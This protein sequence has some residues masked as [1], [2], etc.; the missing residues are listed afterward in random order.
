M[1]KLYFVTRGYPTKDNSSFAFIQ[2]L[3]H[4]IADEGIECVV[5]APQPLLK[6]NRLR[7]YKWYD[8]TPK[9]NVITIIQPRYIPFGSLKFAGVK[10]TALSRERAL[11]R[12]MN[13]LPD[14]PDAVYAHFWDCALMACCYT[15][16]MNVPLI[17]V[18]GESAIKLEHYFSNR[19]I[20]KRKMLIDGTICVST[21]NYN[22]SV[23]LGLIDKTERVLI[24]PNAIDTS[25]FYRCDKQKAKE[26]V[27]AGENDFVISYVGRFSERKGVNR[28]IQAAKRFDDVKLVLIGYSGQLDESDQILVAKRVPHEEVVD[29]LNASDVY[30]LPTQAEGCCNS[31]V[32][33]MACGL[34]VISSDAEFNKD[35]LDEDVA[36]LVDPNNIG[37]IENAISKFKDNDEMRNTMANNAYNKAKNMTIENRVRDILNYIEDVIAGYRAW[38]M[39]DNTL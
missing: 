1:K 2:P 31:I 7:P 35:I 37:E 16:K 30:C 4:K 27:R 22:E 20:A 15:S 19:Q 9:D 14:K 33:A 28:L 18:S 17:V 24:S 34:P 29:Y 3:V 11:L 13:A 10:L 32:E 12:A 21:K 39:K 5:I 38:G 8:S 25:L 23:A 36:I 26:K 6:K